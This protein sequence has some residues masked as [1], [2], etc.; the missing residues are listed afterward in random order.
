M[1]VDYIKRGLNQARKKGI[2]HVS[3]K[4]LSIIRKK[5]FLASRRL[6]FTLNKH[7]LRM[8]WGL[9]A[10][11]PFKIIYI[12][13][14]EIDKMVRPSFYAVNKKYPLSGGRFRQGTYIKGGNW[15]LKSSA[16]SDRRGIISF[17]DYWLYN[18]SEKYIQSN[19][20]WET[21]ESY[22]IMESNKNQSIRA[23]VE[24]VER[25][26]KNIQ[27]N[28]YK[29]ATEL[30]NGN[31][32]LPPEYDEIRVSIGRTGEVYFEDGRHRMTALQILGYDRKIP[33]RIIVRHKKWQELR[34]TIYNSGIPEGFEV[35]RNH[36]DLQDVL[37]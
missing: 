10:P 35:L 2:L 32:P 19:M 21:F 31:W 23:R 11:D 26:Y 28:G 27:Q 5:G 3:I 18:I 29:S 13:P 30:E 12:S 36:P 34:Y 14:T 15:D 24:K 33:V 17:N 7:F 25:L 4:S 8:N 37:S 1:M 20:D 16:E 22:Y 6:R 9:S